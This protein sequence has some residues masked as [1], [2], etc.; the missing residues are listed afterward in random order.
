MT[1][2]SRTYAKFKRNFVGPVL[3]RKQR[4]SISPA[5]PLRENEIAVYSTQKKTAKIVNK[6]LRKPAKGKLLYKDMTPE[7]RARHVNRVVAR[8]EKIQQAM[9]TWANHDVILAY[10][11]VCQNIT[12]VTGIKHEVDHIIPIQH[13]L[14][15]GL[16]VESN[17][18]IIT[19]E[20]NIKKSNKF[21]ID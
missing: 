21:K 13:P 8:Q 3:T 11:I 19:E 9:P 16:H 20:E 14:V 15:C 7:Q 4:I 18:Q 12:K 17:L 10:Y 2:E 6:S 1:I 5:M